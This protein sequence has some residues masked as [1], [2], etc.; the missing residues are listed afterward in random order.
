M[1]GMMIKEFHMIYIVAVLILTSLI[2]CGGTKHMVLDET[3]FGEA[4]GKAVKLYT[5]RNEGGLV[6]K[7]TNYGAILTEMHVPDREGVMA[8]VTLG[9]DNLDDYLGRH[10]HFGTIVG[11]VANRIAKGRFT[12]DGKTYT[13]ATNNGPNHLH[14]GL[15]AFD[16]MVWEGEG[17]RTEDGPAVK[18][19]Y[20]SKDGEEGYPGNLKATV[21]Y[22][23]THDNALKVKM[24]AET[25]QATPVNLAQHA[26]W[27]LKGEGRGTILDHE[28]MLAAKRYTP[29]DD[30]LIPTGEIKDVKGSP[31][32]FTEAKRIDKDFDALGQDPGGYDCNFVLD[33][34]PGELRLAAR[35]FEPTSGR[36]MEILTDQPGVQFYTGNFLDGSLKGLSGKPYPKYGGFCLETQ[37]FPDSVNQPQWPSI[38]LRPG[39]TYQHEMVIRFSTR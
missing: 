26:Y 32:D 31:Y 33:G 20:F 39:E 28:V 25:D 15:K 34:Q 12:L 7:I 22:T 8:N 9:F 16:R 35:V 37:R 18:L 2:G 27:N 23:L 4:D 1:E 10:P 36:I 19:T 3:A 30:T 14:G 5:L 13:L 38:I 6:A 24:W 17:M 29:T 21:V 11:R